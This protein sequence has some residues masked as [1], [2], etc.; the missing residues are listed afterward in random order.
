M[1][2]EVGI[3]LLMEGAERGFLM[4]FSMIAVLALRILAN[5]LDDSRGHGSSCSLVT[6]TIFT[7]IQVALKRQG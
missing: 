7:G 1:I 2:D 6:M 5:T 4:G 3:L